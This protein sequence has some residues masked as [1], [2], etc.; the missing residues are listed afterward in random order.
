MAEKGTS[1]VNNLGSMMGG[2]PLAI[3][4]VLVVLVLTAGAVSPAPRQ[5]A[6]DD[7]SLSSLM[8]SDITYTPALHAV[9]GFHFHS[10]T[11]GPFETGGDVAST[12]VTATPTDSNA[13]VTI[14][15]GADTDGTVDLAE[16][17]N[18]I[19]VV[20]TAAD[21]VTTR[22]YA[23][24]VTRNLPT[25]TRSF[26]KSTVGPGENV[27]VTMTAANYGSGGG[28]FETLPSGF[29]YV[30]TTGLDEFQVIRDDS[31]PRKVRFIIQADSSWTYTVRA[32]DTAGDH[33]FAGH[34]ADFDLNEHTVTGD[35]T[36]TVQPPPVTVSFGESSYTVAESDDTTTPDVTENEVTVT[37]ELSAD[38]ERTVIIPITKS[39]QGTTT[40]AD[41]SGVPPN[42]TFDSGE[43]SKTFT[44]TR[45]PRTRL[46]TTVTACN[47]ASGLPCR[48]E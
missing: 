3:F 40:G 10:A 24:L 17:S 2:Y 14:T 42:V 30:S 11:V 46:T 37:V 7:A 15:L 16:G 27:V 31:D 45:D 38:P 33:T 18:A 9:P 22:T 1:I 12:T 47:W 23:I 34:L 4:V 29:T 43:T 26:D 36:V 6:T 5:Q 32:S 28:V 13:T 44:F 8:L 35:T 25:A 21:S 19:T 48:R 20:V 39:N 41:Y